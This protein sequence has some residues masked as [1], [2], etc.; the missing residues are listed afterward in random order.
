MRLTVAT[1]NIHKCV[2]RDGVHSPQRIVSVLAELNA[3]IVAVQEF[4]NRALHGWHDTVPEDLCSPLGMGCIQQ[5]TMVDKNGG[6]HGN[7]LLTR[8]PVDNIRH[9]DLGRSGAETR[10]AILADIDGPEGKLILAAAHFGLSARGRRHQ[11]RMLVSAVDEFSDG[12]SVV[13]MGDFNEW[14]PI[15]GCDKILSRRF[16]GGARCRSFPARAPLLPLDRIWTD[17][18]L[19]LENLRAHRSAVA[20]VASDHLPVVADVR[21]LPTG[22]NVSKTNRPGNDDINMINP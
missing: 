7:L 10:R 19:K 5:P 12:H 15:G 17:G 3:D 14:L 8:A 16:D 20:K 21:V 22:F 6:M 9:V 13:L 1:Y 18:G 4:D 11:A 2:G